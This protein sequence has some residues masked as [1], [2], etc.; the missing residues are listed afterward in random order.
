MRKI[1]EVLR[2]HF[3][4]GLDNREIAA[5]CAL[6]PSTVHDYLARANGAELTW[7]QASSLSDAEVE[8]CLFKLVGRVEPHERMPIDFVHVHAEMRRPSVT[9]QLLWE[10]YRGERPS[11]GLRPYGYSQFCDLYSRWR[12][13]LSPVMRQAH[14]GGEKAFVDYS[15]K[16]PRL[17]DPTT[18]ELREVE[19]FVMVLG[20]SNYT[21]AEATATQKLDDFI[22]SHIR[23]FEYFGAVSHTLIP[24][25]LRSAVMWPHRYDPEINPTYA[26]LAAHYGTAVVPARPRRPRDKAKVEVA[27][28]IVQRWILARLRARTFFSLAELNSAIRELLDELN[29]RQSK[30]LGMSRRQAFERYDLPAM[31]PLRAERFVV[32][33]RKDARVHPDYTVVYDERRYSVPSILMNEKVEIRASGSTIE[34]W[35]DGNRVALHAR[36]YGPVHV[37]IIAKEHQP[38]SHR[39]YGKWPPGRLLAWAEKTGCHVRMTAERIFARYPRPELGY[40]AVFGVLRL[41]KKFGAERLDAACARALAASP[42][43]PTCRAIESILHNGLDRVPLSATAPTFARSPQQEHVRGSDYYKS[44]NANDDR[45]DDSE[46]DV[47]QD[48]IDG[49]GLSGATRNAFH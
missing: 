45:R 49:A 21:F 26:A 16:K 31:L 19:L 46:V 14:P 15:G 48:A 27:V 42:G 35:H 39:E 30:V 10:E 37:P 24:D 28:Q 9:L 20:A 11:P 32:E 6:S 47:T 7:A 44:E 22:G 34:V 38:R 23:A 17:V 25:Q 29:A 1:R 43:C 3:E 4:C 2:L 13:K 40:R 5:S 18:G 41:A 33:H 36:S 12:S 8:A